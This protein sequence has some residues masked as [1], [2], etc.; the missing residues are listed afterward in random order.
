MDETKFKNIY[1][2]LQSISIK[3]IE[4]IQTEIELVLSE[5]IWFPEFEFIFV[6]ARFKSYKSLRD[7]ISSKLKHKPDKTLTDILD[8]T[9]DVIGARILVPTK[10]YFPRMISAIRSKK[11]KWVIVESIGYTSDANDQTRLKSLG[12]DDVTPKTSGYE[13]IHFVIKMD[14]LTTPNKHFELQIHTALHDA[15]AAFDHPLHKIET[16]IEDALTPDINSLR[17]LIAKQIS[18]ASDGSELLLKQAIEHLSQNKYAELPA[19]LI[20]WSKYTTPSKLVGKIV[21]GEYL[22]CIYLITSSKTRICIGQFGESL[23]TLKEAQDFGISV[24]QLSD[25]LITTQFALEYGTI[26]IYD[27]QKAKNDLISG[28]PIKTS[29]I[30]K[31]TKLDKTI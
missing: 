10:N 13:G 14:T 24:I 16:K 6:K 7:K 2:R 11:T 30:K 28:K 27:I 23:I 26:G 17:T 1:S 4:M 15:W 9:D 18:S 29:M 19:I 20:N 25:N 12:L 3:D 8:E 5:E 21:C 31:A 22:D